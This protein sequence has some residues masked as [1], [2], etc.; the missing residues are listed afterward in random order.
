VAGRRRWSCGAVAE[1]R[2]AVLAVVESPVR[3]ISLLRAALATPPRRRH[4]PFYAGTGG[5]RRVGGEGGAG[6]RPNG[7]ASPRLRAS[8]RVR[9]KMTLGVWVSVA[10]SRIREAP[11]DWRTSAAVWRAG[12]AR[13]R[14]W[15]ACVGV[16]GNR[17]RCGRAHRLTSASKSTAAPFAKAFQPPSSAGISQIRDPSEPPPELTSV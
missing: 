10:E 17:E 5:A 9:V 3:D 2:G 7:R 11:L 16:P 4:L 6:R 14:S 13:T 12:L 8:L 15:C 1:R